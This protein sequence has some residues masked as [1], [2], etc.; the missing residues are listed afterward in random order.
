MKRPLYPFENKAAVQAAELFNGINAKAIECNIKP[1]KVRAKKRTVDREQLSLFIENEQKNQSNNNDMKTS[2]TMVSGDRDLFGITIKH[3]TKPDMLCL[4]DLQKAYDQMRQKHDWVERRI[5]D[6]L[7]SERYPENAERIFYVLKERGL[8]NAQMRAFMEQCE[9]MTL[10]R[11]LKNLGLYKTVG[12]G[13]NKEVVCNP[14]IFVLVAL[15]LN[16]MFY[17]KTV[18]WLTDNLIFNR[19]LAGDNNND[20]RGRLAREWSPDASYYIEVNR[21]LNWIIFNRHEPNIRNT[22]TEEELKSLH[23]L[24][25]NL[26]FSIDTGLIKTKDQLIN[27]LRQEYKKKYRKPF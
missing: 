26:T 21:A 1:I 22:A 27:I 23:E 11:V 4:T 10:I 14:D 5:R 24:E 18:I 7:N 2:V 8:I 12:R 13:E 25:N 9:S 17:A 3:R 15:E 19:I 20:L 6:I 16:P